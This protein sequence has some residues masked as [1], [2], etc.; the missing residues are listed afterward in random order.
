MG[1]HVRLVSS[2]VLCLE[3]IVVHEGNKQDYSTVGA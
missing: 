2:I 3:A 1:D